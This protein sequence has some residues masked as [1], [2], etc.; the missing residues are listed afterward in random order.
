MHIREATADDALLISQIIAGSW[1]NAY[2]ELIDPVYL[3][4]LP[5]EYW[6]PSMRTWL[7]SGRMYGCIAE[8]H[9]KPVGSVIYGRGRDESHADWGEIV[10]LYLLPEAMRQGIGHALLTAALDALHADGYDRVYLWCIEGNT[11]ADH[12]Y[13]QHGFRRDGGR[14]QYKIGSGA[15]ADIR[16]IREN[17]H[18]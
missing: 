5:E 9:G 10:S 15:V 1:R 4:R 16:F 12:F 6:M 18:G 3:S 17:N 8:S 2:Q 14:V 11:H 7:D 13:Q